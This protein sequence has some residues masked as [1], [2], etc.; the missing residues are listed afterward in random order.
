[1][2]SQDWFLPEHGAGSAE[3]WLFQHQYCNNLKI[4]TKYVDYFSR[5]GTLIDALGNGDEIVMIGWVMHFYTELNGRQAIEKFINATKRGANVILIPT[6]NNGNKFVD[7]MVFNE[8][9]YRKVDHKIKVFED[10]RL[11]Y[12][13]QTFHQKAVYIKKGNDFFFFVG[14]MDLCPGR[15]NW[16]D[17]MVELDGNA[18]RLGVR[19]LVERFSTISKVFP[20]GNISPLEMNSIAKSGAAWKIQFVRTYSKVPA[21]IPPNTPIRD[22]ATNGDYTYYKAVDT[23]IQ[24]ARKTIYI[25][26]QFFWP[27]VG[28]PVG[29]VNLQSNQPRHIFSSLQTNLYNKLKNKILA[30]VKVVVV[31]SKYKGATH[32]S[33]IKKTFASTKGNTDFPAFFIYGPDDKPDVNYV[34]SKT[35]IVD[36]EV[37]LIGSGNFSEASYYDT[38]YQRAEAELGVLIKCEGDNTMIHT[39]RLELWSR[40]IKN[41]LVDPNSLDILSGGAGENYFEVEFKRLLEKIEEVDRNKTEKVFEKIV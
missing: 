20:F 19:N 18:A 40:L 27:V 2:P 9:V 41:P 35:I 15:L 16:I 5:L 29:T 31:I 12:R 25:E 14:G 22:F 1:M 28:R 26:D 21:A 3:Y 23:I 32:K 33:E 4:Y 13:Y 38:A 24:N 17:T 34:H 36:D 39:K 6:G 37:M 11:V 8:E 30:G 10:K 7:P